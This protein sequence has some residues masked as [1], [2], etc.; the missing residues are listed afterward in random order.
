MSRRVAVLVTSFVLLFA[1]VG[2]GAGAV[3]KA[4]DDRPIPEPAVDHGSDH[5]WLDGT[6]TTTVYQLR[7]WLDPHTLGVRLHVVRPREAADVNALD[8][9]P[10]SAWFT[11]RHGRHRLSAAELA[12]IPR[13]GHPPAEDGPLVVVSLKS[14]GMTPGFLVQD[15]KGDRYLVKLDP[16]GFPDVPTGAE[17]VCTSILWA[18]GWNVPEN[19]LVRFDPARLAPARGVEGLADVLARAGRLPDGRL[20][21]VAS[22]LIPGIPKGG[23]RTL[24]R[25]RDDPNDSVP[26]QD[27]RALRGLRV[28]AAWLNYTD[29]RRGNFYDSFVPDPS[30][31]DH[32]GHLVHY[33]LDFS[34]ALGAGNDDWKPPRYGHEYVFDPSTTLE[35]VVT[36]GAVEPSWAHVPLAHPALGYLDAASFDP[37]AWRTTYPNPLFDAA[38]G[39]DDF[40]GAKL[41]ASLDADELRLVAR[42][43]EWTDP[44]AADVLAD[45]LAARARRIAAAYFDWRRIAPLDGFAVERGALRFRDLAIAAGV[46]DAAGVVYRVRSGGGDWW[47]LAEPAVPLDPTL[48]A[49]TVELATSHD[50][51]VHWSPPTRVTVER[52]G[53]VTAIARGTA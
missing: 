22:R 29:A 38:T 45:I 43:G 4:D 20:R 27:R 40:W 19:H 16:P 36:F 2:R 13:R 23:F 17:M 50:G 39:R 26:H 34:S 33:L 21:A 10:D 24:G 30:R 49:T 32:A 6:W 25:R 35:R 41:V 1:A 53:A 48:S 18:L 12:A 31:A 11:N 37:V 42:A 44:R 28:V 15:A 3:W 9:V 7:H 46:A 52:G 5:V 51:G 8:E 47:T 14:R